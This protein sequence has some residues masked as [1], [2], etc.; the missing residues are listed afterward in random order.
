MIV[1]DES[2]VA[3]ALS[4][5]LTELG[6]SIVGPF[7]KLAD[8]KQ[9]VA[10]GNVD[11]AILDVN[12]GGEPIYP[13]AEILAERDMPFVFT[14]GYGAESIDAR[15][16]NAPILQKPI[17]Q[18]DLKRLFVVNGEAMFG[19]YFGGIQSDKSANTQ[20]VADARRLSA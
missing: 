2:L 4:D 5:F 10:Q 3:L 1:E 8:A 7:S 18:E 13:L 9:A 17:E 12:L 16:K 20:A 6:F 15:F 11:A 19:D 14:T